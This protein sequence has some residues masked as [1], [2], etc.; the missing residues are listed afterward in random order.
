MT[1]RRIFRMFL[2]GLLAF[3]SFISSAYCQESKI[4]EPKIEIEYIYKC[5]EWG[6]FRTLRLDYQGKVIYT[7]GPLAKKGLEETRDFQLDR[8]EL[9]GVRDVVTNSDFFLLQ[10]SYSCFAM[11]VG[12]QTL[13]ISLG[14]KKK[15][16]DLIE[17]DKSFES[18]PKS[19]Y[20][21]RDKLLFLKVKYLGEG[22]Y[23]DAFTRGE[24]KE[25]KLEWGP[26]LDEAFVE[27]EFPKLEKD[28]YNIGDV[29]SVPIKVINKSD[30]QVKFFIENVW[31]YIE[32]F[33]LNESRRGLTTKFYE[34]KFPEPI[35]IEPKSKR[36]IYFKVTITNLPTIVYT[37]GDL[38]YYGISFNSDFKV[39]LLG[40]TL[41]MNQ[42]QSNS[43]FY[44]KNPNRK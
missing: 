44:I 36:T 15:K 18:E 34:L 2:T 7:A 10:D 9:I 33:P 23:S 12:T 16:I 40:K 32:Y 11:D 30:E 5:P 28:K 13:I 4:I 3:G 17:C 26:Y 27:Y 37:E 38:E 19:F 29:V 24:Y 8:E 41:G 14:D 20:D 39:E 21:I 43:V 35:I 6:N 31:P 22:D 42:G 25:G 1:K